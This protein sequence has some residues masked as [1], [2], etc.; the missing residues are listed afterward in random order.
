MGIGAKAKARAGPLCDNFGA[1]PGHGGKQPV[2]AALPRDEFDLP[3]AVLA[4]EF[5]VAFGDAQDIVY[6]LDPFAGNPVFSEHGGK[7]LAQGRAEALGLQEQGFRSLGVGLW[8]GQ[9]LG[10]ALWGDNGR[11]LQEVN[12]A[13]P[14][15]FYI[16]RSRVGKIDG[17]SAAEQW[18]V[19]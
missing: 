14:G 4:Y 5:I 2:Q 15:H 8:Q 12:E 16:R 19:G 7:N 17:E 10:A 9:K 11:R 18:R 3:R 13:L 1:G 6:R